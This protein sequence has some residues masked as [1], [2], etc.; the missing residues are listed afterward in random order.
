MSMD[1]GFAALLR[2]GMTR[3]GAKFALAAGRAV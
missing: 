1:A 3:G 2:P